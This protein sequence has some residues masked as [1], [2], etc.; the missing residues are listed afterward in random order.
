MATELRL[1][2]LLLLS[3]L[4]CLAS[5]LNRLLYC[6]T[7][8]L[9]KPA[10]FLNK[11]LNRSRE[12]AHL[13]VLAVLLVMAFVGDADCT[14]TSSIVQWMN[15]QQY[16]GRVCVLGA[17][18]VDDWWTET[19]LAWYASESWRY[20]LLSLSSGDRWR[21]LIQNYYGQDYNG[22]EQ[23]CQ[24]KLVGSKIIL[25]EE[26]VT[27]G[28]SRQQQLVCLIYTVYRRAQE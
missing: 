14:I 16:V 13:L 25:A 24:Q 7:L 19:V 20:S 15:T 28:R 9:L 2:M 6:S 3:V 22:I 12:Q 5:Q 4:A 11:R 26:R 23:D 10:T 27:W 17:F 18:V 8:L 21:S 1:I